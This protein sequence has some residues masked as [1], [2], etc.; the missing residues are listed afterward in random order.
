MTI[1]VEP[2]S[3]TNPTPPEAISGQ[4]LFLEVLWSDIDVKSV[5]YVGILFVPSETNDPN[6]GY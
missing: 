3:G 6:D 4:S 5:L 1:G 2:V